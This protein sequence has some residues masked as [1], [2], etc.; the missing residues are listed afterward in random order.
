MQA[1]TISALIAVTMSLVPFPI[2]AQSSGS[3]LRA[4]V[5][6]EVRIGL[7]EGQTPVVSVKPGQ[8]QIVLE[9]P[10]DA[11]IPEDFESASGGLLRA[12]EVTPLGDGRVRVVLHL[13]RGLLEEFRVDVG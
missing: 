13:A 7:L 4:G 11:S 12:A 3:D 6:F 2:Q 9:L 8:R 1:K 10:E 5:T